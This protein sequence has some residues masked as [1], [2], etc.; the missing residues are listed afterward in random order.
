LIDSVA[1]K[2]CT[3]Q[4]RELSWMKNQQKEGE[5]SSSIKNDGR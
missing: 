4:K 3:D 2:P 5:K 1:G